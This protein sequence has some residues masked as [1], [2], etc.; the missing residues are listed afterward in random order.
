MFFTVFFVLVNA[1]RIP[2]TMSQ[3][4][5]ENTLFN[6]HFFLSYAVK[7]KVIKQYYDSDSVRSVSL[8]GSGVINPDQVP[9]L[10]QDMIRFCLT[11]CTKLR[12]FYIFINKWSN[13]LLNK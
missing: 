10:D 2:R 1:E 12:Q 7:P 6:D 8:V 3:C 13:L 4:E 11:I 9:N 5:N